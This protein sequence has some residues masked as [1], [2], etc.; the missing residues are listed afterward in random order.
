MNNEISARQ[1]RR[2]MAQN[3]ITIRQVAARFQISMER[4]RQVRKVGGPW[5]WPIMISTI[6]QE[7]A[8]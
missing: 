1:I 2:L 7:R 6:A 3:H 8:H 4:V 5:D